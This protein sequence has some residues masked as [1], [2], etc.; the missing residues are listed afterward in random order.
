MLEKKVKE[1]TW[2]LQLEKGL[3][4]RYISNCKTYSNKLFL[5]EFFKTK[6]NRL[7]SSSAFNLDLLDHCQILILKEVM[8]IK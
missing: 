6:S 2:H 3:K 4:V 7:H 5:L 8:L 1:L